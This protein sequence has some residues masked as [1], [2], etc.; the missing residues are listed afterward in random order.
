MAA[1][2]QKRENRLKTGEKSSKMVKNG[3]IYAKHI[4]NGFKTT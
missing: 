4:E 1:K 2:A 3:K